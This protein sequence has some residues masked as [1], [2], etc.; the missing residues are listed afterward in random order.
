MYRSW[1]HFFVASADSIIFRHRKVR[2]NDVIIQ[3]TASKVP[4]APSFKQTDEIEKPFAEFSTIGAEMA[5]EIDF[6][7]WAR[8]TNFLINS[9]FGPSDD[10]SV[11]NSNG[12]RDTDKQVVARAGVLSSIKKR[13]ANVERPF[14]R[15]A[16]PKF[17]ELIELVRCLP[18]HDSPSFKLL[19]PLIVGIEM[20]EWP[21]NFEKGTLVSAKFRHIINEM[22]EKS[23]REIANNQR[24]GIQGWGKLQV[25]SCGFWRSRRFSV[26]AEHLTGQYWRL[27]LKKDYKAFSKLS[28][29]DQN[30]FETDDQDFIDKLID[31]N[32]WTTKVDG[33]EIDLDKRLITLDRAFRFG[34]H[35]KLTDFLIGDN[36]YACSTRM[37]DLYESFYML[38]DISYM[39]GAGYRQG[40][41]SKRSVRDS[42]TLLIN[43]EGYVRIH[44]SLFWDIVREEQIRAAQIRSCRM[45]NCRR[46]FWAR[47]RN[48]VC[49]T[50]RCANLYEA[51]KK[52]YPTADSHAAYIERWNK[53]QQRR[54]KRKPILRHPH[55][56]S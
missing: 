38:H 34:L 27:I 46:I 18:P 5:E 33:R 52:R 48:Q 23:S 44:K 8:V 28:F 2:I 16:P 55:V 49:C 32:C 1:R 3:E 17:G 56:A 53:R 13:A 47:A 6:A 9:D 24:S 45:R 12:A 30:E 39:T 22:F 4:P 50:S 25:F 42:P 54:I 10:D 40:T 7:D 51:H 14:D 36:P 15:N 11:D 37:A 26:D 41:V 29:E 19:H 43:D 20:G 31:L 35:H 21:I